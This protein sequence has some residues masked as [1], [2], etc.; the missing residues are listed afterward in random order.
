[1]EQRYMM[2]LKISLAVKNSTSVELSETVG[3][4]WPFQAIVAPGNWKLMPE[5][6]KW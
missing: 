6:E 1:M 2:I 3:W 5:I 4:T